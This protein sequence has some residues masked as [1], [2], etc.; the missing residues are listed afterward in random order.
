VLVSG[1]LNKRH[2]ATVLIGTGNGNLSV[3]EAVTAWLNGVR[4][5][6]TGSMYDTGRRLLRITFVESDPRRVPEIDRH[7][8][9]ESARQARLGLSVDYRGPDGRVLTRIK[10][11]GRARAIR[12]SRAAG[13]TS[14]RTRWRRRTW[15][16]RA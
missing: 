12:R 3:R 6:L 9:D 5:A 1:P 7:L 2:L 15:P 4:R 10:A 16:R 8:S 13:T 14:T 11:D